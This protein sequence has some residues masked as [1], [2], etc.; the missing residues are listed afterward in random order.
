MNLIAGSPADLERELTTTPILSF[1]A[2]RYGRHAC[3]DRWYAAQVMKQ[4]LAYIVMNYDVEL[5]G[6]P[7]KRQSLLNTMVSPVN[8]KMQ[9]RRKS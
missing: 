7:V 8:K 3:P 4:T 2:L 1:L 5:L 6:K 9:I